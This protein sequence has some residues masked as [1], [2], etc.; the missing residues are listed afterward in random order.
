MRRKL[1]G[2]IA[3]VAAGAGAA[4]GQGPPPPAPIGPAGMMPG[5]GSP[6]MAVLPA[7]HGVDP[8]PAQIGQPIPAADPSGLFPSQQLGGLH[9]DPM[10]EAPKDR[11]DY[12]SRIAPRWWLHSEYLLWFARAMPNQPL[13]F[14]TTSAPAAGGQL[15]QT[16]TAVLHSSSDLGFDLF[17]G[18]RITGGW[19]RDDERRHGFYVSGF[20]TELKTNSFDA[21]S[22][23]TGQPLLARPFINAA[24]GQPD[25]LLVSFPTF[26]AGKVAINASSE[27]WGAEGGP[28][29]NIYRSCPGEGCLWD[30]NVLAGFRFLQIHEILS[31]QSFTSTVGNSAFPFD[32]KIYGAPATIEVHDEIETYN[33][34]YG[35]QVGLNSTVYGGRWSFNMAGKI[36]LGVMHQRVDINGFSILTTGQPP[37]PANPLG[38]L[39]QPAVVRAGLF[40]NAGNIGRYN[41][42]E[43]AVVPEV[44]ATLGYAWSSWCT[45]TLGYTF[46]YANRVARPTEQYSL[47]VNPALIPTS[48][49]YGL[50]TPIPVANPVFTQ[51]DFWLQGISF[52]LQI[53]Y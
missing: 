43:F 27:T 26:A 37:S 24:T 34:F 5:M 23:N 48:P 4:W 8:I 49:S 45:T 28:T 14:V 15:G 35:G 25:V 31:M 12:N 16:S 13:P 1:I 30:I 53:K 10:W 36:A 38:T 47:L 29:V 7:G 3:A 22:D 11:Y 21:A 32:G 2:T 42:D 6:G 50:G 39:S 33:Q 46:L 17:S 20:W 9:G 19:Y 51:S 44:Q 40:A 18:F 41:N 52:G